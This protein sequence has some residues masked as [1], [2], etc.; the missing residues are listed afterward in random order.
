MYKAITYFETR[1]A[2]SQKLFG[3]FGGYGLSGT[4]EFSKKGLF[5]SVLG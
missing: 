5:G 4:D 2:S 3:W 1:I